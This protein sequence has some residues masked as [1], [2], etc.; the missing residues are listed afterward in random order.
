MAE[1]TATAFAK[2]IGLH[3]HLC[4]ELPRVH[5]DGRLLRQAVS[6]VLDNAVRFT[7][8]GKLD[9]MLNCKDPS[10]NDLLLEL[11]TRDTGLGIIALNQE[12]IFDRFAQV[13]SSNTRSFG[14][15]GLGL[16]LAKTYVEMMGGSITLESVVGDGSS[17]TIV[18]A[19]PVI[20]ET[21]MDKPKETAVRPKIVN[22]Q[23][24]QISKECVKNC[25]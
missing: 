18:L 11:T 2:G 12:R 14:G 13:E 16:S 1:F 17:F 20:D 19:L 8:K 9:V 15:T 22:M 21:K 3:L 24:V 25:V 4:E 6:H 7:T 5:G 23:T 10:A